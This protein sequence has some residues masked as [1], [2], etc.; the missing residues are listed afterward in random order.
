MFWKIITLGLQHRVMHPGIHVYFNPFYASP[1]FFFFSSS[2]FLE[3]VYKVFHT[4]HHLS[5]TN[6]TLLVASLELRIYTEQDGSS[7]KLGGEEVVVVVVGNRG[8]MLVCFFFFK[9]KERKEIKGYQTKARTSSCVSYSTILWSFN[10]WKRKKPFRHSVAKT[11]DCKF[12]LAVH[13]RIS[14][15]SWN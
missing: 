5:F 6:M 1:F 11:Q 8:E 3:C 15:I 7:S 2:C 12:W 14:F 13:K 9:G 10:L 4:P